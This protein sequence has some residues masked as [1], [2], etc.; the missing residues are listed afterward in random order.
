MSTSQ[1]GLYSD[2]LTTY[3]GERPLASL[4]EA[5]ESRR[6]LDNIYS[7]VLDECLEAGYWKHARRTVQLT[8]STSI[9]PA[10]GYTYAFDIPSDLDTLY[11]LSLDPFP[12]SQPWNAYV[13]EAGFIRADVDTLYVTY[14]SNDASYGLKLSA[15]SP[16]FAKWVAACLA[17][18]V[19]LPITQSTDKMQNAI[20][21]ADLLFKKAMS[22]D[23]RKGPTAMQPQGTWSLSRRGGFSNYRDGYDD[24]RIP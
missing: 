7:Q 12:D 21:L 15:W 6:L 11:M 2:A 4:T 23:A 13:F 22:I 18:R 10:F 17:A 19:A 14:I 16:A 24:G 8:A 5:R 3:L 1:L 9:I 20:K